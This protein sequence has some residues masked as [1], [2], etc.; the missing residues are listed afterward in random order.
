MSTVI[1]HAAKDENGNYHGGKAGDQ[2]GVEVYARSWYNRPWTAA[3]EPPTA[4]I[5]NKVAAAAKAGANNENIGYDQ[6][7]RNTLMTEAEK[8]NFDLSKI[9]TPC[10]TDCSEFGTVTAIAGG[11]AT[12][13]QMMKGATN[14][15]TSSTIGARLIAAG[16]KEH[17]ESKFLTTSDNIGPGWI[18][19]YSGHHVAVNG[20]AGKNY[21]G[22]SSSNSGAS[23]GR[24][25]Y[26]EPGSTLK[27]GSK[28]T[29]VSWLQWHL[30]TLIDKDIISGVVRLAV[31]GDWGNNTEAAFKTFQTKYPST[32]TN[33]MPD[34]K[35]G[36]GSRKKLKALVA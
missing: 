36:S 21:A 9:A 25:P 16:W 10:E 7:Q 31:D 15:P 34:G 27:K 30:N 14:A 32:G 5:G 3:Y 19:V 13:T 18:L 26:A 1:Y 23:G 24:C 11:G 4:A 17:K 28:G 29:G 6:Y 35:C 20:T 22:G 8:V 33:N 12:K 2:T